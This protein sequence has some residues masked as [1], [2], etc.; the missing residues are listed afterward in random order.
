MAPF[1]EMVSAFIAVE[2]SFEFRQTDSVRW[3]GDSVSDGD[4]IEDDDCDVKAFVRGNV[5]WHEK[6]M[7]MRAIDGEV[8][9]ES[10][11]RMIFSRS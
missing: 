2:Y 1:E 11:A 10:N 5:S 4:T 6:K 3:R 9:R 7:A 8:A